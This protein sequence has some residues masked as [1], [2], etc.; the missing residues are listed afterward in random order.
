MGTDSHW[1]RSIK[2]GFS[3]IALPK[4]VVM[5][6]VCSNSWKTTV[7]KVD[8]RFRRNNFHTP[9]NSSFRKKKSYKTANNFLQKTWNFKTYD[10]VHFS[11]IDVWALMT[12]P[13]R[14]MQ[15]PPSNFVCQYLRIFFLA[16][17]HLVLLYLLIVTMMSLFR[18]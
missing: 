3:E 7:Q 10:P 11:N 16:L 9:C 5:K 1:R 8:H 17:Y 13:V 2:E 15:G 14:F 18:V 12:K 4:L 6:S